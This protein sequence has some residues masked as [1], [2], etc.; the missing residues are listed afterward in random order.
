ML[1]QEIFTAI[2][3]ILL[4]IPIICSITIGVKVFYILCSP[5]GIIYLVLYFCCCVLLII[6]IKNIGIK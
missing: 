1:F 6:H 3:I 5:L 4:I 2:W